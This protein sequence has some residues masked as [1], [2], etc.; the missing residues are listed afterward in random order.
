[1][2]EC[3]QGQSG[4]LNLISVS[5]GSRSGCPG[6]KRRLDV[7]VVLLGLL[8]MLPVMLLVALTIRLVSKGPIF[9]KQ[10]RI[11]YLGKP[12]T[13]LK[14][15]TMHANAD[16]RIHQAHINRLIAQN[17]PLTKLDAQ[18]D[19][20]LISGGAFLRA[21]CVDELPQLFNVLMGD[22]S[23]VGPRP[24]MDYEFNQLLP[25]HK[26]RFNSP[27]GMTGLWQVKRGPQTSF[28][29]MMQMDLRYVANRTLWLDLSI[30]FETVPAVLTQA[31]NSRSA[32]RGQRRQHEQHAV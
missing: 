12:F 19:K 24:C 1:M 23:L 21:S 31:W 22:M 15:R 6:W 5:K 4:G 27:P 29:E 11:G 26:Q 32:Q 18:G 10:Q 7:V 3:I 9:F 17:L 30:L 20:R 13:V 28:H 25:W 8:I 2:K 16:A 14:F